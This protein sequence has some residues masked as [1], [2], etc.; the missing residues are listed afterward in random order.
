[1]DTKKC[2]TFEKMYHQLQLLGDSICIYVRSNFVLV[3]VLQGGPKN[4]F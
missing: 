2:W 3:N 4:Q 1:M